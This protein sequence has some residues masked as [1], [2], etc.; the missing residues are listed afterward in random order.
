MLPIVKQKTDASTRNTSQSNRL[1]HRPHSVAAL[2][3][4]DDNLGARLPQTCAQKWLHDRCI[5]SWPSWWDKC[6]ISVWHN[7][8]TTYSC[9]CSV[10]T[11]KRRIIVC[12]RWPVLVSL[13]SSTCVN[14]ALHCHFHPPSEYIT[15]V[16][17]KNNVGQSAPFWRRPQLFISAPKKV[18]PIIVRPLCYILCENWNNL[19]IKVN[20]KLTF[21]RR[22]R[23]VTKFA[24][25]GK[26]PPVPI[27]PLSRA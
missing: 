4:I 7:L 18:R 16:I 25:W 15:V 13:T 21:Y 2:L 26:A 17:T 19:V 11:T 12:R 24:V 3:K 9:K 1:E 14:I 6:R 20:R 22:S 10:L 5:K 23:N 8:K 27:I